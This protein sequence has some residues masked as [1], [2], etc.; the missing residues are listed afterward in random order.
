MRKR[1]LNVLLAAVLCLA[2][3]ASFA[4]ATGAKEPTKAEAK[5]PYEIAVVV[6]LVGIPWFSAMEQGVV[7]AGKQLGV[8]AYLT[9]P[10]EAD[11]AQQVK[12]VEDM[13]SKGVNAI[14]VVPNDAK[15]LEPVFRKA[16]G[17]GI[18]L[19]TN[20]SP[21][22]K[23]HDY[24]FEMIDNQKFGEYHIDQLVKLIGPV[25]EYAVFVGSLTVP[26]HNIWADASIAYAKQKYPGLKL[27]TDRIP[28]SEDQAL[29]RQKTLELIKAYPNLR[30]IIGYGS[31]GPPGAAQAVKEKGLQDQIAVIG[32]VI[33]SHA[34]PFLKDGSLKLGTLW[35]PI[36]S[37]WAMVDLAKKLL[38]GVKITTNTEILK[39][40]K[41]VK[42]E[43]KTIVFNAMA[44]FTA[45]N[46]D[47]FPF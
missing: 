24:D 14:G 45:E 31:L 12:I 3:S 7:A 22:Q 2:F 35:N 25:G 44:V 43:G 9:G 13:V 37:G 47:S 36:D 46:V 17:K 29:S 42:I 18:V 28:C 6:K 26:A 21:L 40:G 41:P 16:K 19:V 5:K 10:P 30:G 32:T 34:A 38:D 33:P 8:N 23:E 20:E 1:Y 39:V 11:E 27:V 4:F 15:S